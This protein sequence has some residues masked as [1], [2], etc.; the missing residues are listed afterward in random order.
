M[1]QASQQGAAE[2]KLE[3]GKGRLFGIPLADLGWFASLLIGLALGF[4]AFFTATFIGIITIL[5]Y[6]SAAHHPANYALSYR[7]GG[8]PAGLLVAIAS[9]AYLGK[10]WA[11]RVFRKE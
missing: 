6:S 11:R 4:V 8:L 9:W 5:F 1:A 10:Q 7:W 2:T 3:T